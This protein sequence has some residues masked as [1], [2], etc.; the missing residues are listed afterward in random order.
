MNGSIN[1]KKNNY[2]FIYFLWKTQA[3][4]LRM[5]GAG[6]QVPPQKRAASERDSAFT[7]LRYKNKLARLKGCR[8]LL[9]NAL[10]EER[11]RVSLRSCVEGAVA[12]LLRRAFL[13][14]TASL[15]LPV[16]KPSA[17]EDVKHKHATCTS[18]TR[19]V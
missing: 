7:A 10:E 12:P 8:V 3:E 1:F 16:R 18:K 19:F 17:C 14:G 5:G 9:R 15:A 4:G 11:L 13:R 2:Y 6:G